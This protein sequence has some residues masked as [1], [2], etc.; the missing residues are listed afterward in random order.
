MDTSFL[1]YKF[2]VPGF[3][4]KELEVK[5]FTTGQVAKLCKVGRTTVAKWFDTGRLRGYRV[6]G[7]QDRRIPRE[8][9]IR[10]LKENG[11]FPEAL[12][13]LEDETTAKVLLVAQD[14]VMV[15]QIRRELTSDRSFRVA[16][17]SSGFDAG[18][19]AESFCPDCIVVD[20]SIG[21]T[22]ALQICQNLRRN[23]EFTNVILVALVPDDGSLAFDRSH[24]NE[25]FK[26]P[27]DASLLAERL[28]VLI[29]A[30]KDIF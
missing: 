1:V 26:K 28:R 18:I 25:T 15:E 24:I 21:R 27:F 5:V 4:A 6:P 14:Q 2:E 22:E 8:Y 13:E 11:A 16:V 9:L 12:R 30:H 29:G 23:S 20:F 7:S 17:A 19:Q 3:S 10:F